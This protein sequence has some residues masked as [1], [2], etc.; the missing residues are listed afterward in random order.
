MEVIT[1]NLKNISI[2]KIRWYDDG[3][4]LVYYTDGEN[5]LKQRYSSISIVPDIVVDY[6]VKSKKFGHTKKYFRFTKYCA[7]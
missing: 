2:E 5:K 1:I 4:M 6:I 7:A 3:H